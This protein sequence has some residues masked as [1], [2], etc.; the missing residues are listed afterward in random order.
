MDNNLSGGYISN[1]NTL[2]GIV[3][4]NANSV[5]AQTV[6]ATDGYF[7]NLYAQ[8][9]QIV[10]GDGSLGQGKWGSFWSL[11]TQTNPT[12]NAVNYMTFNNNDPNNNGVHYLT[13]ST[14]SIQVDISG[15]YNIQFSAQ[16]NITQ[17]SNGTIYIW[18]RINGVNVAS[19]TGK[20]NVGNSNGQ[21]IAWNY[22]LHLNPNDYIQLVWSSSD[23]HL[24]FLYE[25]ASGSPTKPAIPSVILTLQAVATN[26]K[27]DKGEDGK[28]GENGGRGHKGDKGN[29][30]DKGEKGE[31]GDTGENGSVD[32]GICTGIATAV[33]TGLIATYD[34]T[35]VQPQFAGVADAIA[36]VEGTADTA[37]ADA[38]DAQATADAVTVKTQYQY[39]YD[40][41]GKGHTQFTNI[42]E[43]VDSDL[44]P[45]ITMNADLQL[46]KIGTT[47]TLN[48]VQM[49]SP[50]VW[51]NNLDA[52][53][54]VESLNIGSISSQVIIK[55]NTTIDT[56]I[57]KIQE[58][59][60]DGTIITT[61]GIE[62]QT[63]SCNNF[64]AK[65]SA[66]ALNIGSI[67]TE[68]IIKDNTTIDTTNIK[69]QQT[70]SDGTLIN[71]NGIETQSAIVNYVDAPSFFSTL[72]IG[73]TASVINI[74]NPLTA[75]VGVPEIN[76]YGKINFDPTE[77]VGVVQQ[78]FN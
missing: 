4:I 56:N 1:D 73:Q 45:Q 8:N 28:N 55:N 51:C 77:L 62:T 32:Y 12:A 48:G 65:S 3:D 10:G 33:A 41:S 54:S 64:N 31:K 27:G 23:T 43:V 59:G 76:L 68:V 71:T 52:R 36:I 61:D 75:A 60:S 69:I 50:S 2:S 70:G 9:L 47:Q 14:N 74:G 35:I 58:T 78:F 63:I 40:V 15:A 26:I 16:T 17:G 6:T 46:L 66:E 30:G 42:L 18:L 37:L 39:A 38:A 67:S 53:E 7:T 21:I 57:I 20:E 34:T 5:T 22:I 72:S 29:D 13:G 49:I 19:T 11:Q 44:F 24:Q 25:A